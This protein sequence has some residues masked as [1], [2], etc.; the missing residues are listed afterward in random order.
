MCVHVASTFH[1]ISA[2]VRKDQEGHLDCP[3]QDQQLTDIYGMKH[4][5][6]QCHCVTYLMS[7][8]SL[9]SVKNL[10]KI[11]HRCPQSYTSGL[12]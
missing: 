3:W 12:R 8:K 5:E 4:N 10:I 6:G 7:G 2:T 9:T 11:N 1:L